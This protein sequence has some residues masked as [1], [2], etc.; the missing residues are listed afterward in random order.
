M[1]TA[2]IVRQENLIS[3]LSKVQKEI[4]ANLATFSQPIGTYIGN[5]PRTGDIIDALGRDR[6]ASNY[7]VISRALTRLCS[8]GLISAFHGEI[9]SQGKGFRYAINPGA[10][11]A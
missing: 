4:L 5:L 3:R 9:Y 8:R 10:Q 6:T 7:A 11:A 2:N 1:E